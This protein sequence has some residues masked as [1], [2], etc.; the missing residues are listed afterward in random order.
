[1]SM[2][3]DHGPDQEPEKYSFLQE[4]IKDEAFS[5]KKVLYKISWLVGKGLLFGVAASIGFFALKPW[6][7]STFQK[8]PDKIEIPKDEDIQDT[9]A[10]DTQPVQQELT[11]ESYKELNSLLAQTSIEAKKCVVEVQGMHED[12]NLL[13]E[14]AGDDYKRAGVIVADNGQ[15]LLI[16][17]DVGVLTDASEL[18]VRFADNTR[19]VATLKKKSANIGMAIV[20]VDRSLITDATWSRIKVADLGNSNAMSQGKAVIAL[21]NPFG[22]SDGMGVGIVSSIQE[23][24]MLADGEYKVI[25][26]D[27]PGTAQGSGILFNVD[28]AVVGIINPKLGGDMGV[29]TAYGISSLKS[30]IELMSNAKE[31]PYIGI[32]GTLVTE[33]ISA[34]QNIPKG[35]CVTEVETDS[36]AMKAGIQNGDIITHIDKKKIESVVGYHSTMITQDVGTEVTLTGQRR[37]AEEY[38]E[39]EFTVTIGIKE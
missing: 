24:V 29:M 19:Y 4:K 15:E 17:T 33:E 38:V 6:A 39:I 8:N 23:S 3:T 13:K 25:V 22:Y 31:V 10:E 12:G 21:G 14:D 16:L 2:E 32:I 26:T 37:G 1:M 27:M 35:F 9:L 18:Q 34:A 5:R 11:I 28:G 30:E 36:P 7:E 20:G